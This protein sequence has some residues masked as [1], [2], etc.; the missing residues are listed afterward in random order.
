MPGYLGA[1]AIVLL[2]GMVLS[3]VFLMKRQG[4][5]AVKFGET[6]KTDFLIPPFA[7]FYFYLVFAAAFGWPSV[8]AQHFFHSAPIAWLGVA[9][10]AAGL[11]MLLW[12]LVSFS[13]SFRIGI[14]TDHPD[15]LITSG[16]F[17][18]SRNPIY[19]AFAGVLIGE[20]L[21]FPNWILLVYLA[22]FVALV[23]RQV[24]REEDYLQ[25]HY[26]QNYLDYCKRVRRYL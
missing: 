3:R 16:I 10:C 25:G 13:R 26:G 8:S 12:S 9:T 20:F 24:L 19:V 2:L 11:L 6:D 18:F 15:K 14:D 21:T 4:V 17:A 23:H 5:T 22:G 1:L 7:L